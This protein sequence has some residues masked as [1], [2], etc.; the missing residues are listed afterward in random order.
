MICDPK[1]NDISDVWIVQGVY[2][3]IEDNIGHVIWDDMNNAA[4]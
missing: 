2:I 4:Q 3:R 1:T